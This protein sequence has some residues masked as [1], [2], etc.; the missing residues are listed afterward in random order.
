MKK[1]FTCWLLPALPLLAAAQQ[2]AL[3]I[4]TPSI[5]FDSAAVLELQAMIAANPDDTSE[6]G[7]VNGFRRWVEF[8]KNRVAYD[9]PPDSNILK[10][11]GKGLSYYLKHTSLYCGSNSYRGNWKSI[12]PHN[13]YYGPGK[14]ELQGRIDAIWADTDWSYILA[15]SNMGGLWKTTDTGHTWRNIT[16]PKGTGG[17]VFPGTMGVNEIAVNPLNHDVIYIASNTEGTAHNHNGYALGIFYSTNAGQSWSED[18]DFLTANAQSAADYSEK[19]VK[20]MAYMPGTDKLF[21]ISANKVLYKPNQ[22]SGWTEITPRHNVQY[23]DL[24]FTVLN[25]GKLVVSTAALNDTIWF[26]VYNPSSQTWT[27]LPFEAPTGQYFVDKITGVIDFSISGVDSIYSVTSSRNTSNNIAR[28][29]IFRT[30]LALA[31][32]EIITPNLHSWVDRAEYII[33]SP[34]NSDIIYVTSHDGLNSFYRSV[35][36][37]ETFNNIEGSVHADAR[38]ILLYSAVNDATGLSDI[39]FGGTDGGVVMKKAGESNFESIT[40]D[41]LTITQFYSMSNTEADEDLIVGGAQDNGG[42]SFIKNRATPW[43][44]DAGSDG[45]NVKFANNGLRES[46]LQW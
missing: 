13:N 16:D 26:Y 45:F 29:D 32:L 35:N 34:V 25:S 19:W 20:K 42:L 39:L 9:A 24:E 1:L 28:V 12:G 6:G 44:Q 37:G 46:F 21:A 41:S 27:S 3:K 8:H 17:T 38:A 30:P 40:G 10:P 14:T 15:G 22:S 18:T 43:K 31:P 33:V 2:P 36:R 5:P 11:A 7:N 23:T 4:S